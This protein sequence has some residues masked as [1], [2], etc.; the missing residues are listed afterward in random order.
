M[1]YNFMHWRG[2]VWAWTRF[3]PSTSLCLSDQHIRVIGFKVMC[4]KWDLVSCYLGPKKVNWIVT[5]FMCQV[6]PAHMDNNSSESFCMCL[7]Y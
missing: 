7:N 6:G 4:L 3:N 1:V 5:H 2:L